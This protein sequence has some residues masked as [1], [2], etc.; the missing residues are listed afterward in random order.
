MPEAIVEER[1]NGRRRQY[2]WENL[3]KKL[4]ASA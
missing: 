3:R 2:P 1:S 4:L